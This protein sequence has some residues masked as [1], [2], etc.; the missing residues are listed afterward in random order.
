MLLK[1]VF[2]DDRL[3]YQTVHGLAEPW[4]VESVDLRPDRTRFECG[5]RSG[6]GRG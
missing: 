3:F 1:E 5:W 4:G 2:M 6:R